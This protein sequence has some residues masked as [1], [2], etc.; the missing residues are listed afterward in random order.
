MRRID[1][2]REFSFRG[3]HSQRAPRSPIHSSIPAR[4]QSA[5]LPLYRGLITLLTIQKR[6]SVDGCRV[7]TGLK[8]KFA[9]FRRTPHGTDHLVQTQVVG[10]QMCQ[11]QRIDNRHLDMALRPSRGQ[12]RRFCIGD[13]LQNQQ[14]S[15]TAHLQ[16]IVSKRVA[17]E[18]ADLLSPGFCRLS[19]HV[20]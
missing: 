3:R 4:S 15:I 6:V 11:L 19:W 16:V 9:A 18:L 8:K 20:A 13:L 12:C 1:S 7:L 10:D 14:G 5:G 2:R 17:A